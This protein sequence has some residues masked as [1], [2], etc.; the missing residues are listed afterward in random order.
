VTSSRRS[1]WII[2]AVGLVVRLLVLWFVQPSRLAYDELDYYSRAAALTEGRFVLDEGKRPPLTVW[3]YRGLLAVFG[4]SPV[5]P[6]I[7]NV[8]LGCVTIAIAWALGRRFG[9]ERTGLVAGLIV[10]VY[11]NL[12]LF[13]VS[14]WSECL[15]LPLAL[16]SLLPLAADRPAAAKGGLAAC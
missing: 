1:L 16:G 15:Y 10:A 7:A 11:P 6:R 8:L 4:V 5:V 12:V 13:S 9:N 2:L 3:Y 14:L